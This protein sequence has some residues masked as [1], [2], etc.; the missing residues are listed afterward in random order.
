MQLKREKDVRWDDLVN[1][2]R[3]DIATAFVNNIFYIDRIRGI[4]EVLREEFPHERIKRD[5]HG[6]KKLVERVNDGQ[7]LLVNLT[8]STP[9]VPAF[10]WKE[11]A[12]NPEKSEWVINSLIWTPAEFH[13]TWLLRRI[14]KPRAGGG[15]PELLMLPTVESTRVSRVKKKEKTH[16]DLEYLHADH[17]PVAGASYKVVSISSDYKD[18]DDF[19]Y[20]GTLD[21][22]GKAHIDQVPMIP[23]GSFRYS[24]S[25]DEQ[26]FVVKKD[27]QPHQAP[28][29]NQSRSVFHKAGKW[30]WNTVQGDFNKDQDISS[31]AANSFL[32][33]IPEQ[34]KP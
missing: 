32:G 8:R 16:I 19:S 28:D 29:P 24:F 13:L 4:D 7:V 18:S 34:K 17:T 2:E 26:E 20:S 33:L 23:T 10:R 5:S 25:A 22:S 11:D 15:T 14:D 3:P 31:I 12:E 21:E 9:F 27:K 1:I 30:I 6:M